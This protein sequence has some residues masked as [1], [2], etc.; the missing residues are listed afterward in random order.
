MR[1]RAVAAV[2]RSRPAPYTRYT[3]C[4]SSTTTIGSATAVPRFRLPEED[5]ADHQGDDGPAGADKPQVRLGDDGM[6]VS[7]VEQMLVREPHIQRALP[8]VVR[9]GPRLTDALGVQ[10]GVPDQGY[11]YRRGVDLQSERQARMLEENPAV[12]QRERLD[13]EQHPRQVQPGSH[14]ERKQLADVIEARAPAGENQPPAEVEQRLQDQRG[15][16]KQP[17]PGERLTGDQDDREQHGERDDELL[18]LDQHVPERKAGPGEVKHPDQRQAVV[19]HPRCD[20]ERPLGEVEDENPGDQ[21]GDVVRYAPAGVQQLAEDQEIDRHVQQR[22]EHLPQLAEPGLGVHRHVH[23]GGEASDE[24]A[25]LPKLA[26]VFKYRRP[27]RAQFESVAE[28]V[29]SELLLG[30]ARSVAGDG[31]GGGEAAR[32]AQGAGTAVS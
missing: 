18:Q 31:N 30:Q 7:S 20:E 6:T 11:E 28:R 21:E 4:R 12:D 10:Y 22:G 15:Y 29:F 8:G 13:A 23:R 17:V 19:H 9:L 24:M 14:D 27:G 26:N 16:G 2:P 25:P 3:T 5:K 32:S 1:M